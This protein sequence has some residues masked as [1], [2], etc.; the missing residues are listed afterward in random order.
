MALSRSS[1]RDS[2]RLLSPMDRN[3]IKRLKSG[4]PKSLRDHD[5]L[6]RTQ[7]AKTLA[8]WDKGT[9]FGKDCKY[10]A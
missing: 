10:K 1:G 7:S 6:L 2:I 9:L 4:A 8:D 5:A 3:A